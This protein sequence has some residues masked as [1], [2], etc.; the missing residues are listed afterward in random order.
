M[1]EECCKEQKCGCESEKER[2]CESN[3]CEMSGEL[4]CMADEA[5]SEL[6]VEK[7]KA[8]WEKE[9]GENMEKVADLIIAHSMEVWKL[10]MEK[11]DIKAELEKEKID[12]FREELGKIFMS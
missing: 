3:Y 4:V 7:L 5:W 1:G 12:K 10:R 2:C 11:Q 6:M 8:R 9:R